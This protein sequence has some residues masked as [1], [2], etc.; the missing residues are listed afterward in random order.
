MLRRVLGFYA[1]KGWKPVI[2]PELEFYLVE[3]NVDPDYPLK[4]P[5]GPFRQA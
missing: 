5:I 4:P 3:K 2:A 1:A